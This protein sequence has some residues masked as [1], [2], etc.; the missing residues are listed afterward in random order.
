DYRAAL[1]QCPVPVTVM[2]GMKSPL[3]AP[4]GQM[5]IAD[6]APHARIVR[7]HKSGHVPLVDEPL[8]FVRE[9]GRFLH[10]YA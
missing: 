8:K 4:A 2:V 5:A 1:R 6:Y 10:G 3:Y 7:F 9:L